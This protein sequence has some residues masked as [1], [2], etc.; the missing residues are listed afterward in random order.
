MCLVLFVSSRIRHTRCAL[1][2]GVQTCALPI[3]ADDRVYAISNRDPFSGSNVLARGLIGD[4]QGERVVASPIY[5][6]HFSL[7]T[8]RCLEDPTQNV[9]AYPARVADRM[10]WVDRQQLH[11]YLPAAKPRSE[12]QRLV[13]VG[14]GIAGMR[15]VEDLMEAAPDLYDIELFSAETHGNYNRIH[16]GLAYL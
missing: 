9:A 7:A 13:V 15:V 12:K 11:T 14:N 16:T 5:K 10:V 8:G 2:T 4:L 1:V 3:C 6:Q